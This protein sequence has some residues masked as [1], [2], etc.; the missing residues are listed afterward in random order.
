[1][2][3]ENNDLIGFPDR[4]RLDEFL[5]SAALSFF[6]FSKVSALNHRM[7][8]VISTYIDADTTREELKS[9]IVN[10][11]VRSAIWRTLQSVQADIESIM[12]YA[13]SPRFHAIEI[14]LP[15]TPKFSLP[16]PAVKALNVKRLWTTV[17]DLEDTPVSPFLPGAATMNF[18]SGAWMAQVPTAL[19]RNPDTVF[20]RTSNDNGALRLSQVMPKRVGGNWEILIVGSGSAYDGVTPVLIQ[21]QNVCRVTVPTPVLPAGTTL[22][23]VYTDT[24]QIIPYRSRTVNN[25]NTTTFELYTYALV[26]PSFNE[27]VF[28]LV[29]GEF[30][31]LLPV[32]DFAYQM[33]A[34]AYAELHVT[35]DCGEAFVYR[36]NPLEPTNLH[37]P[38]LR[39]VN[40]ALGV[41]QLCTDNVEWASCRRMLDVFVPRS[42]NILTTTLKVWYQTDPILLPATYLDQVSGA[43]QASYAKVAADLPI[44]DCNCKI[45]VGYISSMQSAYGTE[46]ISPTTQV[47]IFKSEYGQLHGQVMYKVFVDK[48]RLYR[49]PILFSMTNGV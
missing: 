12:G 44:R 13:L 33:V 1:M 17:A 34:P 43:V 5:N 22:E 40:A 32:I 36:Y 26:D 4:E 21:D 35:G 16:Q 19:V 48:L 14:P 28:D 20:L 2:R 39:L 3:A 10:G 41:V 42:V 15:M 30:Y 29:K 23:P 47:Q 11:C 9:F 46:Y 6:G 37:Y 18:V 24:H 45:E 7:Y 25:D 38:E 27:G 8:G 31:K 49:R